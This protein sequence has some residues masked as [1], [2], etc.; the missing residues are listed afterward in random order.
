MRKKQ[1]IYIMEYKLN[2]KDA[3]AYKQLGN[4]ANVEVIKYV[5][6]QLFDNDGD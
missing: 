5:A 2:S 4:S 6:Q 1:E 3:V